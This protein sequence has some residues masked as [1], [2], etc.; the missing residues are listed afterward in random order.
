MIAIIVFI[1]LLIIFIYV[2]LL[3]PKWIAIKNITPNVRIYL[4]RKYL[5][6]NKMG[7]FHLKSPKDY[8][9]FYIPEPPGIFDIVVYNS[10]KEKVMYLSQTHKGTITNLPKNNYFCV[11]Y[12]IDEF[13]PNSIKGYFSKKKYLNTQYGKLIL[14]NESH[15]Y[16][17]YEE[18]LNRAALSLSET[19]YQIRSRTLSVCLSKE[20][21]NIR[22]IY[23]LSEET[24][25]LVLIRK[26]R[27]SYF[28]LTINDSYQDILERENCGFYITLIKLLPGDY[29]KVYESIRGYDI[30]S[31]LIPMELWTMEHS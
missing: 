10:N 5:T 8:I 6:S 17:S 26:K 3:P 28:S 25:D 13:C 18:S 16:S 11:M 9:S 30:R 21:I 24:E 27:N 1:L 20:P 31:E 19:G 23:H 22:Y 4:Y 2:I 29:I 7:C 12:S 15:L 14:K